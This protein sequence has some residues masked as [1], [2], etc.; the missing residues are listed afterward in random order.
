M[1]DI[2]RK[3]ERDWTN[4]ARDLV[5][6]NQ[7]AAQARAH[8][9]EI[10]HEI[11]QKRSVLD[12]NLQ[13]DYLIEANQK[14]VLAVF[15][16]KAEQIKSNRNADILE[17]NEKLVISALEAKKLQAIAELGFSQ[18][19]SALAMVA[20]E[21][22]N[23]LTPISLTADRLLKVSGTELPKLQALIQ[24]QVLHMERLIE[25]LLDFSRASTG[26]LNLDFSYLD[27][28]LVIKDAI[29]ACLPLMD[30]HGMHFYTNLPREPLLVFGDA[31]RLAQVLHNL[32]TNAVK[33]TNDGGHIELFA[34]MQSDTVRISI[35]DDGIGISK[36]LLPNIFDPYVQDT[37]AKAFNGT[38]LGIGLTVVRELVEAHGGTVAGDSAG[39][40]KGSEFVVTLPLAKY[41]NHDPHKA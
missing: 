27:I 32:F 10:E 30:S 41:H 19:K 11:I 4:A 12:G 15:A 22:R 25:D 2:D 3:A 35:R 24:G 37:H 13:I 9:A 16:A 40:S 17:A 34:S 1:K 20:H 23:P 18:Q 33:Y 14:L 31:I 39:E 28:T 26:K 38:G 8:L 21:L 7:K 5:L 6:L 29:A 36:K